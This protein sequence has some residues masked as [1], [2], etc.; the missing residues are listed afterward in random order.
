MPRTAPDAFKPKN[1][2]VE[3]AFYPV[4]NP[5]YRNPRKVCKYCTKELDHN[6]TNLQ[7]HLDKCKPYREGK[8]PDEPGGS[9]QTLPTLVAAM[10]QT[11][12]DHWKRAGMAVFMNNLPFNHYENQYV[13]DHLYHINSKYFVPDH[14]ALSGHILNECYGTVYNKVAKQLQAARWL[15]FYTD[16][17]N[18]IRR[19]RVINFLAHAPPGCGTDGGCFYINSEINGSKTMDAGAQLEYVLRQARIAT[20]GELWKMN[21]LATDTCSSMRSLWQKIQ[22]HPELKH[23]FVVPCDSH[24]IQLLMKDIFQ[25]PWWKKLMRKAQLVVRTFR[26]AH[27]EYQVLQEIEI[28][29]LGK[30]IA[31][32]LHCITRWGTQVG[33]LDALY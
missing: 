10:P 7:K 27:K 18:N 19:Q 26:A 4:V 2:A 9:Q 32:V 30:R 3:K 6:T 28:A 31:L 20:D 21:S 25:V 14:K 15:N 12:A 5:T 29:T 17:S 24:G 22:A 11:K 8:P 33:L 16:E 13:R 1:Q 23:V